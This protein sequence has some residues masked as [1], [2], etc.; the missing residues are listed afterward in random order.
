MT[1]RYNNC[2]LHTLRYTASTTES[3]YSEASVFGINLAPTQASQHQNQIYIIK[4]LCGSKNLW[5]A[6]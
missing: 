6:T 5:N 2:T 1:Q 4:C 3:T